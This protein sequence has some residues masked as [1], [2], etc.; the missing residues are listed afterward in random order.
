ML[1]AS[2]DMGGTK[3]LSSVSAFQAKGDE[4]C[5]WLDE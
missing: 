2:G 1:L 3:S 5:E 4:S